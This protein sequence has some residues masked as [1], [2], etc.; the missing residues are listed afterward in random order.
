M[1]FTWQQDE[2]DDGRIDAIEKDGRGGVFDTG[3]TER[4]HAVC[5]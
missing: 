3:E 1:A 4:R 5:K 2:G